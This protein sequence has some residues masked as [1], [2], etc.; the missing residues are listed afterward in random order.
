MASD[1]RQITRE[2][3]SDAD[4]APTHAAQSKHAGQAPDVPGCGLI[5]SG[6]VRRLRALGEC[7]RLSVLFQTAKEL[8]AFVLVH[9]VF[10]RETEFDC[11]R[12]L[13]CRHSKKRARRSASVFHQRWAASMTADK[14]GVV[15]IAA[16]IASK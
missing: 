9:T 8:S 3:L 2:L 15:G 11:C 12:G 10:R 7:H 1:S 13:R 5:V 4:L 14:P 6:K 16:Q